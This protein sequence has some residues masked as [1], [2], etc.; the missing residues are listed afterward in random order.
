M[1]III[2]NTDD[3][4]HSQDVLRQERLMRITNNQVLFFTVL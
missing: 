4:R 2:A 3:G 1:R